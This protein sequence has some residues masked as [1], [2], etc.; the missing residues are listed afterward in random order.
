MAVEILGIAIRQN[1]NINGLS[2]TGKSKKHGQYADDLWAAIQADDNSYKELLKTFDDFANISGLNVNYDKSQVIR[3]GAL[4][5]G[6]FKIESDKQ[7]KWTESTKILGIH[8]HPDK[9]KMMQ[10]N[11]NELLCKIQRVLNAWT[12]RSCTLIGKIT[13]VNALILSQTVYKALVL[14][15]PDKSVLSKIKKII[16][17]FLWD[18]KRPKIAYSNLIKSIERGGLKLQD[19]EYKNQSLKMTW[20][21]KSF[22]TDNIWLYI[23]KEMVKY[24]LPDLFECNLNK[25]DLGKLKLDKKWAITS[26]LEARCDINCNEPKEW[27]DVLSQG[28]WFNSHIRHRNLPFVNSKMKSGRCRKSARYL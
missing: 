21:K 4:Q 15:T 13:I 9:E 27:E 6:D 22:S 5:G 8:I 24:N 20:V 1:P 10:L 14:N 28:L 17:N 25:K 23:A 7:L 19:F 2:L 11:Y 18:N 16:T 26:V 3:I 12:S